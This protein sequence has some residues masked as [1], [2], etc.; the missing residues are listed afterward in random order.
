MYISL[1]K[2]WITIHAVVYEPTRNQRA[3]PVLRSVAVIQ[4]TGVIV[5]FGIRLAHQLQ[6]QGRCHVEIILFHYNSSVVI[7]I[8]PAVLFWNHLTKSTLTLNCFSRHV[9]HEDPG[10][11]RLLTYWWI[12]LDGTSVSRLKMASTRASWVKMYCSYKGTRTT[13]LEHQNFTL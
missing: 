12:W 8:L 11:R 4:G 5:L 9:L 10:V 3:A 7:Q 1:I 2:W 6:S 13:D